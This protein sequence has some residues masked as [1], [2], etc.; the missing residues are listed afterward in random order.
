MLHVL[1][2]SLA[3]TSGTAE[4]HTHHPHHTRH[5]RHKTEVRQVHPVVSVSWTWVNGH[6]VGLRWVSGYWKHP[7][8]GVSYRAHRAGPPPRKPH[9]HARWIPGHWE[10]RGKRRVWVSGRWVIR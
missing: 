3:L 2:T 7:A 9:A 4:A 1:L 8:H 6:Y 10:R 5:H